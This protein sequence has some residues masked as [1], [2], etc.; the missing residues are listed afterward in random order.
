M[1]TRTSRKNST[2]HGLFLSMVLFVLMGWLSLSNHAHAQAGVPSLTKSALL[3]EVAYLE[4]LI[5]DRFGIKIDEPGTKP[6]S[7]ID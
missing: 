5:L 7:S 2:L 3:Q 4:D 1:K 6:L